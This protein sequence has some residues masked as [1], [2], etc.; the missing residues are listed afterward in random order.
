MPYITTNDN[1]QIYYKDWGSASG[2]PVVFCHGWPLNSDNF[3]VQMV[4]LADAGYRSVA[5]DRRGSGRS[6]QPWE[7]NHLDQWADDL[8]ELI[9]QL[10]LKDIVLVGHSTGGGEITRYCGK[11]GTSRVKKIVLIGSYA[12]YMIQSDKNP[13]GVPKHVFDHFRASMLKNRSKFF[14]EIPT[15]PFFGY[16]RDASKKDDAMILSWYAIFR[17]HPPVGAYTYRSPGGSRV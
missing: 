3:E 14:M 11:H 4:F 10:D 8:A 6:S 16:N 17:F 1:T 12:P 15:G 9:E 2:Q 7:G 5:H 13:K